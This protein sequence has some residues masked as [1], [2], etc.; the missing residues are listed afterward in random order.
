MRGKILAALLLMGAAAC[1]DTGTNPGGEGEGQTGVN[2]GNGQAGGISGV[3]PTAAR[4]SSAARDCPQRCAFPIAQKAGQPAAQEA[5]SI[6]EGAGVL[7]LGGAAPIRWNLSMGSRALRVPAG[8]SAAVAKTQNG[9]G[10]VAGYAF[11]ASNAATVWEP[12]GS[13]IVLSDRPY[14]PPLI[15]EARAINDNSVIVGVSG[16]RAFRTHYKEGFRWLAGPGSEAA[17]VNFKGE[18]VGYTTVNGVKRAT[19]WA[20]DGTPTDLGILPGEYNNSVA[21]AI[22]E[23]GIVVGYSSNSFAKQGQFGGFIWTREEGLKALPQYFLPAD[24]NH[25]GEVAGKNYFFGRCA[26][27]YKGYGVLDLP[28]LTT[29]RLGC[30]ATS[31]NSWGDVAGYELVESADGRVTHGMPLVWTW[32]GN[33]NRYGF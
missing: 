22:S 4:A 9:W 25:W 18:V 1:G 28:R 20:P 29:S 19:L 17:D 27:Y 7:L 23:T 6:T 11:G 16:D 3:N 33:E 32:G 31:I 8:Y 2:G 13:P 5:A 30:E 15:G 26:V 14:G 12:D 24:V 21:V 10:Q